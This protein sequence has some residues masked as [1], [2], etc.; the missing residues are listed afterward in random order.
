M[1]KK[2]DNKSF[3]KEKI[4]Q[5]FSSYQFLYSALI[6][7]F[8]IVIILGVIVLGKKREKDSANIIIPIME[9]ASHSSLNIDLNNLKDQEYKIKVTNYRNNSINKEEMYYSLTVKN[10]TT[11]NV[12]LYTE[13]EEKNLMIDQ[14]ETFITDYKLKA[15]EKDSLIFI[16][17]LEE[18][19]KPSKDDTITVEITS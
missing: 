7:L 9:K 8:I 4:K 11:S 14:K 1:S 15:K 13:K 17:K 18:G 12:L 10:D 3:S 19:S 2:K 16:I 5:F 6:V